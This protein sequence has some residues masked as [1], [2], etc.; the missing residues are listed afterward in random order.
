MTKLRASVVIPVK[1][2]GPAFK[3][4][5]KAVLEQST[6][7]PFEVLVIDSGSSDGSDV[8]CETLPGVRLHKIEPREF[9]HGKTRNLGAA[10]TS[11]EFIVMITHDALPADTLWLQNLVE[12]C[13]QAPDIAG[14]FGRHL[15]YPDALPIVARDLNRH[16]DHFRAHD[17]VAR[18]DDAARYEN[19]EAYRQFLHFFSDNNAC[20]RRAVW[21]SF[22][23][24]D[25]DFAEDQ[26]WAKEIIEARYA[27]AYVDNARVFHSHNYKTV[28]LLRR[29]FDESS[30]L[31][32]LFGYRLC[33][34]LVDVG[35]RTWVHGKD[36]LS[37]LRGIGIEEH[38][39]RLTASVFLRNFARFSGHYL[40]GLNRLPY[41]LRKRISLDHA[42]KRA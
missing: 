34:R 24:P 40:G 2:G 5:I 21:E 20:I 39:L 37:Y 29:S 13:D 22:P 12:A 1:N 8:Y 25:V 18:L 17:P 28:E 6:P 23:Y 4:V 26:I 10:M 15:P 41:F 14:A 33:P 30:A 36:D 9:G 31:K 42:L 38:T 3:R 16:F 11:G 27:K 32:R 19:D 7:W 35:R